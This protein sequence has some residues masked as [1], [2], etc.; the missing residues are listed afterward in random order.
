M[1]SHPSSSFLVDSHIGKKVI[2]FGMVQF[3]VAAM[4]QEFTCAQDHHLGL[5]ACASGSGK[6]CYGKKQDDG[7]AENLTIILL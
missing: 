5:R 4:E 7:Q 6:M 2:T 3:R 1:T